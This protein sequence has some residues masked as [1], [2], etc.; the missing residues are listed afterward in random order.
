[1]AD[2]DLSRLPALLVPSVARVDPVTGKPSKALVDYEQYQRTWFANT[3]VDL[4][5]KINTVEAKADGNTAA[6]NTEQIARIDADGALAAD[7]E[8][9]STTVGE[10]SADITEITASVNGIAVQK[11]LKATINGSTGGYEFAGVQNA[12]GSGATFSMGFR[13][14][15]FMLTDPAYNG[16]AAGNVFNYSAGIFTFN[17]P[18]RIGTTF[19]NP[20]AVSQTAGTTATVNGGS[21]QIMMTCK[22]GYPVLIQVSIAPANGNA[23][24]EASAI[25]TYNQR[26]YPIEV[27]GV[28]YSELFAADTCVGTYYRGHNSSGV[29]D[30]RFIMLMGPTSGGAFIP[31]LSAGVRTFTVTNPYAYDAN[32]TMTVLE[33]AR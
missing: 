9:V 15:E 17:V 33:M 23:A 32:I 30:Y 22:G 10:N 11:V 1:M 3:A 5:T 12:D 29:D 31:S 25:Y 13:V 28:Q 2:V 24:F 6:I 4:Q 19:I 27:D 7:I 21:L 18:V 20:N 14:N 26:T 8:S 16:G